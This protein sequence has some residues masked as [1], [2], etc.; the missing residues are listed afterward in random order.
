LRQETRLN[1][2]VDGDGQADSGLLFFGVAEA[3][4]RKDIS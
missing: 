3:E 4:I 2:L 1:D